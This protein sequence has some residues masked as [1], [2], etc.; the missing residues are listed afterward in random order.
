MRAPP[1]REKDV[2][3]CGSCLSAA[4]CIRTARGAALSF[5]TL[6]RDRKMGLKFAEIKGGDDREDCYEDL[7]MDILSFA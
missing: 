6:N 3:L 7:I 1:S 5:P 2:H 4:G